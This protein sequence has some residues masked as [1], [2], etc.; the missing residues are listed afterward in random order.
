MQFE[1]GT[2]W[3]C[4][5]RTTEHAVRTGALIPIPTDHAFVEEGGIRFFVRV[6]ASLSRKDE[7][8]TRQNREESAGRNANPFLPPEKDL[9]VT[10]VSETHTAVLNKFNVM[11]HHLLIVTRQFEDQDMLLTSSDFEALWLCLA[12]YPSLGFYNGGRAAGASQQHRHLQ[13]VPLPI[14]PE[15]PRTPIE[16]LLAHVDRPGPGLVPGLP[17]LHSFARLDSG[18]VHNPRNAALATFDLYRTMLASLGM[19]APSGN[20]L[21][22]QSGP[23]CLLVTADWMLIVP[24]TREFFEDVSLNSLAFAGSFFVRNAGQLG[25]LKA[26]GPMN[27]LR[28]VTAPR[29]ES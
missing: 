19:A 7:A 24:R 10:G 28:T 26:V 14:S 9:T 17:F 15:G 13:V 23:Y 2:L 16:P 11:E 29:V 25:R 8:R 18:L 3:D 22:R 20:A 5:V 6:L 1:K 27:A 21:T 12:E 4:I